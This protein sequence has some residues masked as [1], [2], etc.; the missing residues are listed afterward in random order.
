MK[1]NNL[2]T[3]EYVSTVLKAIE[4]EELRCD[5]YFPHLKKIVVNYYLFFKYYL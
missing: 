3:P 1:W 4:S 5:T 2:S